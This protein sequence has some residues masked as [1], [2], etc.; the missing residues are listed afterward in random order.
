MNLHALYPEL[1]FFAGLQGGQSND[2]GRHG[3]MEVTKFPWACQM[4]LSSNMI[5]SGFV[6]LLNL[7][8]ISELFCQIDISSCVRLRLIRCMILSEKQCGDIPTPLSD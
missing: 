2:V 3:L 6:A 5:K 1:I 4:F 8:L 7:S